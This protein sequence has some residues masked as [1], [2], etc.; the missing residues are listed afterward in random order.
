MT[1][2]SARVDALLIALPVCGSL[3]N[4]HCLTICALSHPT[5]QTGSIEFFRFEMNPN[6][7]NYPR[8]K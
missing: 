7:S 1:V 5:M 4:C 2:C 3:Y 8:E 6:L